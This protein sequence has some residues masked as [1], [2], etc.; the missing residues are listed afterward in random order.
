MTSFL[1]YA[2]TQVP[3]GAFQ[4][5]FT[6]VRTTAHAPKIFY[7]KIVFSRKDLMVPKIVSLYCLRLLVSLKCFD[8][9]KNILQLEVPKL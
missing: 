7:A 3:T 5:T 2:A 9:K 4:T 8:L 1:L 6:R